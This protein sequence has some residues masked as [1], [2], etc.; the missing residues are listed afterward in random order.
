MCGKTLYNVIVREMVAN[1]YFL[2]RYLAD[3]SGNT[4]PDRFF[5]II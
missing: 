3:I 2:H 4:T 5:R 1:F